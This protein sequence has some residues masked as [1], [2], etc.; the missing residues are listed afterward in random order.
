MSMVKLCVQSLPSIAER[1]MVALNTK[2]CKSAL[3]LMVEFVEIVFGELNK[4][5]G[6]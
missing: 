5:K 1:I 6:R 3:N 2:N 4:I